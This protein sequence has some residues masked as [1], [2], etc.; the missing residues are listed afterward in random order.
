MNRLIGSLIQFRSNGRISKV[1]VSVEESIISAV[2]VDGGHNEF[3]VPIGGKIAVLF[4]ESE[5]ALAYLLPPGVLS[6][7]NRLPCTIVTVNDDGLLASVCM[8]FHG[9]KIE[10]LITSESASELCLRPGKSVFALIKSTEVMIE[11]NDP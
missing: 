8:D 11:K 5:T 3:P 4:K 6:I 9:S 10:S 2:V 7:R 1:V